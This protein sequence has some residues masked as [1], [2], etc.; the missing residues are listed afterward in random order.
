MLC[1]W[2]A[3]A[4]CRRPLSQVTI[5]RR[6]ITNGDTIHTEFGTP[7]ERCFSEDMNRAA[8][9]FIVVA[10]LLCGCIG[11]FAS[12]EAQAPIPGEE[13]A[14]NSALIND[15]FSI[16]A[17]KLVVIHDQTSFFSQPDNV[18][19]VKNISVVF[20]RNLPQYHRT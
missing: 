1:N 12:G 17:T 5:R 6:R 2:S 7:G 18:E 4:R 8:L 10:L 20:K 15:L 16:N 3:H 11:L 19:I 9:L 14:I 13:Y